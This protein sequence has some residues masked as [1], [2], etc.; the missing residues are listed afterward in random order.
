MRFN[1]VEGAQHFCLVYKFMLSTF[2]PWCYLLTPEALDSSALTP[3]YWRE[4]AFVSHSCAGSSSCLLS[5][6]WLLS[7]QLCSTLD[8]S[9]ALAIHL[10]DL[11][12]PHRDASTLGAKGAPGKVRAPPS[13]PIPAWTL[14]H[15]II[16]HH[17]GCSRSLTLPE[18]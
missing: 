17:I 5:T 1:S 8:S 18:C 11:Q 3:A 14:T 9:D 16:P 13:S 6:V 4:R 2:S 7:F 12:Q 10:M 15:C